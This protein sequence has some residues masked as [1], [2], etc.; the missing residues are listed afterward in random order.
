[1]ASEQAAVRSDEERKN[2][3]NKQL[4]EYERG[5]HSADEIIQ[6]EDFIRFDVEVECVDDTHISSDQSI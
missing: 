6:Q 3:A 5:S 4:V 2:P 1:M